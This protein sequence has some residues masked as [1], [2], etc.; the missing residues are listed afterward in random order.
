[1]AVAV[2]LMFQDAIEVRD[3]PAV[4]VLPMFQVRSPPFRCRCTPYVSESHQSGE[5]PA[6]TV[7]LSGTIKPVQ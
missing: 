2:P 6:V 4:N 1:M 5:L 3:L 7:L